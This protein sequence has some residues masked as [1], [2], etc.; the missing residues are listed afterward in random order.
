M[1]D[2]EN[3]TPQE[4]QRFKSHKC[5][6]CF[7]TFQEKNHRDQHMDRHGLRPMQYHCNQCPYRTALQKSL[8]RHQLIH[9]PPTLACSL[10]PKTF[11][12]MHQL[13]RHKGTHLDSD[14][15]KLYDCEV[16]NNYSTNRQD[17]MKRHMQT[18]TGE[19]PYKCDVC[20]RNFAHSHNFH[21]HKKSKHSQ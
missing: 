10:C 17:N 2:G 12:Y 5:S 19:T 4:A 21:R 20:G 1:E 6:I 9:R 8:D 3:E 15:P 7:K 13:E 18:H 14:A 16:C 11:R